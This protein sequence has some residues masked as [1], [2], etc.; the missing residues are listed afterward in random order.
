[1]AQPLA[2]EGAMKSAER[3]LGRTATDFFSP[4]TSVDRLSRTQ[5]R[6]LSAS[7]CRAG[8]AWCESTSTRSASGNRASTSR[9]RSSSSTCGSW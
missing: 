5:S 4:S 3:P 2:V 1:M 9:P 7:P 8:I 6:T